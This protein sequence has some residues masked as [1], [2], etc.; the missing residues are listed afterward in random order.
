MTAKIQGQTIKTLISIGKET[1]AEGKNLSFRIPQDIVVKEF[2]IVTKGTMTG[3]YP[4]A[5]PKVRPYG[6]LDGVIS[7]LHITRRGNDRVKSF[8]GTRQ[9]VYSVERIFGDGDPTMHKINSLDLSGN[10][11][12]GSLALSPTTQPTS[13]RESI[14]VLME[15]KLSGV[16]YPTLFSTEGLMTAALNITCGS[17]SNIKDPEDAA[18]LTSLA[19]N[20]EI[21]VFASCVDHALGSKEIGSIDFVQSFQDLSFGGSVSSSKQVLS[22]QGRLQGMLITGLKEGS[23]LY[24]FENMSKTR[25]EISYMGIRT[26]EGTLLQLMSVDSN[27][28][29]LWNHRKGSAYVSFLTNGDFNSGLQIADGKQLDVMVTTDPSISYVTPTVLAFEFDQIMETPRA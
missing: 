19:A 3:V 25:I 12:Q 2:I 28:T 23:K 8:R 15:N 4:G 27:K 18:V 1:L 10:V 11:V 29:L 17:F 26:H 6:F 9:L 16:W 22:P 5:T 14:T 21:E 20:V 13:F 7:D 24:D